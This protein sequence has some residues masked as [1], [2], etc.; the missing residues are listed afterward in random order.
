MLFIRILLYYIRKQLVELYANPPSI[1][2]IFNSSTQL[3]TT[4]HTYTNL[5]NSYLNQTTSYSPHHN[6]LTSPLFSPHSPIPK[7]PSNAQLRSKLPKNHSYT[8]KVRK[9]PKGAEEP[10]PKSSP[11]LAEA[12]QPTSQARPVAQAPPTRPKGVGRAASSVRRKSGDRRKGSAH[13]HAAER[14]VA[15]RRPRIH[16]RFSGR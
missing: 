14:R 11:S 13:S 15:G 4:I 10:H 1:G 7:H 8:H 16:V 9:L 2:S 5:N 12:A 3:H 6:Q